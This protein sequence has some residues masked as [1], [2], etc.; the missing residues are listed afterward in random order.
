[1]CIL[2]CASAAGL[3]LS[4]PESEGTE[5]R[6]QSELKELS[7]TRAE[8]PE[9]GGGGGESQ[10]KIAYVDPSFASP[11]KSQNN[12]EEG[13]AKVPQED[14]TGSAEV[15]DIQ[16]LV[17]PDSEKDASEEFLPR[18]NS[19][20][21]KN[22]PG[23]ESFVDVSH[24]DSLQQQNK[25][26]QEKQMDGQRNRA[27]G[28]GRPKE[29]EDIA[30]PRIDRPVHGGSS[31]TDQLLSYG[32]ISSSG[33]K[34][35][36]GDSRVQYHEKSSVKD[37]SFV[38]G[39][40]DGF[41]STGDG[42]SRGETPVHVAEE[43][44]GTIGQR[45]EQKHQLNGQEKLV[46]PASSKSK[47]LFGGKD[48]MDSN[49]YRAW[50]YAEVSGGQNEP[51]ESS[52]LSEGSRIMSEDPSRYSH[53]H[54][55][56]QKAGLD[57]L[58]TDRLHRPVD[59]SVLDSSYV[60][61]GQVRSNGEGEGGRVLANKDQEIDRHLSASVMSRQPL[62]GGASGDDV[63]RHKALVDYTQQELGNPK[64][65]QR[66]YYHAGEHGAVSQHLGYEQPGSKSVKLLPDHRGG[67]YD[68][69]GSMSGDLLTEHGGFD[70][71]QMKPVDLLP[72]PGHSRYSQMGSKLSANVH[73]EKSEFEKQQPSVLPDGGRHARPE[74]ESLDRPPQH[75]MYDRVNI[76]PVDVLSSPLLCI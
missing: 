40:R 13:R 19:D 57:R 42:R 66:G 52:R 12:P 72:P 5:A 61:V 46:V 18:S 76:K 54:Y 1:M 28:N 4:A 36:D 69:T 44:E 74:S 47:H 10:E 63:R 25:L 55:D 49:S 20:G 3:N 75:R 27:K 60:D 38:G 50:N 2:K 45:G 41:Q 26:T 39:A 37:E 23:H 24:S 51:D 62:A 29:L 8:G 71:G 14:R 64:T 65:H 48:K 70:R 7:H 43:D 6:F 22:T 16:R 33:K 59:Q 11:L 67:G 17:S 31:Y 30:R 73:S 58:R 21:R 32:T 15:E 34:Y 9:R 53:G 35:V 56:D 68:R